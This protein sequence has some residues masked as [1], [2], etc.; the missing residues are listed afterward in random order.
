MSLRNTFPLE[1]SSYRNMLSRCY[2]PNAT[3][4]KYYGGRGVK[5]CDRWLESFF[6]FYVDMGERIEGES[7][8]RIDVHGD[9]EPNNCRWANSVTQVRNSRAST[10]ITYRGKTKCIT[11]WAEDLGLKS[12]TLVYRLKR[13]WSL[14]E[15]LG[16][17]K[18][19]R[20]R[21]LKLSQEQVLDMVSFLDNGGSQVDFAK[22]VGIDAS[23]ISRLYRKIKTNE[24]RAKR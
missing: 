22:R 20:K 16:G 15:A 17:V 6:N 21:M 5:V 23:N 10:K 7:L 19:E 9:Y 11:E 8:D 12:N 2:N 4:Y 13:G 18:R 24:E 3:G 14:D 1:E